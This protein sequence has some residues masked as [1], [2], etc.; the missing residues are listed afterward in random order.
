MN[1]FARQPMPAFLQ[2]LAEIL[3]HLAV[4]YRDLAGRPL[5]VILTPM[6][7]AGLQARFPAA[8]IVQPPHGTGVVLVRALVLDATN[9]QPALQA[10]ASVHCSPM[11]PAG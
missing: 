6:P 10:Q 4:D 1:R 8:R 2:R 5:D 7:N 3:E 9:M 11:A